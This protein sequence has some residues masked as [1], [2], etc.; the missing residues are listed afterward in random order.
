MKL[1]T[2]LL[3]LLFVAIVMIGRPTGVGADWTIYG[4][5][6]CGWTRKQIDH[7]KENNITYK[8]VDC[9]KKECPGI[10]GFPTTIHNKTGIKLEGY[11]EIFSNRE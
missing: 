7:M 1:L 10:K 5:M 11:N 8:F 4:S 6:S 3:L 9:S 2:V